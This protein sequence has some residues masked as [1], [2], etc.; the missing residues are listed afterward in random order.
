MLSG[1]FLGILF[2]RVVG[3]I[4][5]DTLGWRWMYFIA[6]GMLVVVAV[7]L[8]ARLPA[9][10][11]RTTQRYPELIRS[12]AHLYARS[13]ALRRASLTQFALG[14]GY[15]GF[16]ATLA[17]ML[18]ATHGLGP[19]AA[20]LIG[21]PGAAGILVARP[22]GRWMDRS[23]VG[24][25]VTAGI[26]L[27]M[28]AFAVFSLGAY[29]VAAIVAGAILLDCGLRAAMVA[30]QTLVTSVDPKARSRLNTVFAAHI[31]GGN[32]V[33]AFLASTALTHAGWW[34]VCA[35]AFAAAGIGMVMH[36]RA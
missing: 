31:W 20:G 26:G 14:I 3:G 22:A 27:V 8:V 18:L 9:T 1:L 11:A 29:W 17:P 19:T 30:N 13:A 33:G 15:G 28:A 35:I 21:I 6:T 32:A 16:W 25:V 23:G 12:L 7:P 10:T 5:A 4:V 34:A 2:A 24:P 36:R